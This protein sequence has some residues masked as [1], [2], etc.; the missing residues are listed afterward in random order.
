MS[1][2]AV[3][4][5]DLGGV[6]VENELFERLGA[7]APAGM[8][9]DDI[10]SRWL[11]SKAVRSFER[12]RCSPGAFASELILEWQL[13][14]APEEFLES[15]AAWARGPYAGAPDLLSEL[16]GRHTLAC[17]SNSNEIHWKK[18][19]TFLQLFD[20]SLSSHLIGEVKPDPACF[21]IALQHCKS[22]PAS[23]AF[24]DD[25]ISNVA[26]AHDLG[27]QAFHV[28]GV[29]ELRFAVVS[30]GWL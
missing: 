16:R 1:I 9:G 29:E 30:Q 17:L 15:F 11:R 8:H 22:D 25:S 14:M 6:L 2:P 3:L 5:F 19:E 7:L 23:V 4:L 18:F 26:A 20:V 28:N 10:K 12:G 13:P 21:A 27:M 24:F